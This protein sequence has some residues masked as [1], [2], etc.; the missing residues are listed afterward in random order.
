MPNPIEL[1]MPQKKAAVSEAL[2]LLALD[3]RFNLLPRLR[4]EAGP[5][6]AFWQ[7]HS[8]LHGRIMQ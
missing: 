8:V 7:G 4:A 1:P 2:S 6:E 3:D 5:T